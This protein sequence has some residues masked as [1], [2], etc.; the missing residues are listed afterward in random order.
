M[1]GNARMIRESDLRRIRI[2]ERI[3][4]A[5]V[6]VAAVVGTVMMVLEPGVLARTAIGQYLPGALEYVWLAMFGGG[7]AMALAGLW[8][9]NRL[10]YA[11]GLVLQSAAYAADALALTA[12]GSTPQLLVT[13]LA[14]LA[15]AGIAHAIVEI[16]RPG[17][18][19][20]AQ[21]S[22]PA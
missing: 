3:F 18:R 15:V 4:P 8:W 10:W 16:A 17:G 6:C 13:I 20:W 22:Q 7:G 1:A 9:L 21:R 2:L 14:G 12:V 5:L 11:G 19:P